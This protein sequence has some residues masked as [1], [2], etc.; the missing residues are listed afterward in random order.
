MRPTADLLALIPE[1]FHTDKLRCTWHNKQDAWYVYRQDA[2]VYVPEKKRG[3]EKRTQL[4]RI[5]DGKW[6]YSPSWLK[7]KEI[8]TLKAELHEQKKDQITKRL[9]Q[10]A[11]VLAVRELKNRAAMV[12]DPRQQLKTA[13]RL[14]HVMAVLCLAMVSGRTGAMAV[15][16][17]WSQH[18]YELS[19]IL[20][21]FPDYDISHDT[22]NR[23]L[24]L[25][26]PADF[27][28]LM[29]AFT[30][31]IFR[32]S[33]NR[34]IH[35]D[36]KAVRASKTDDA[37][38]GRYLLNVYDSGSRMFV[39]HELVG[40]KT[41]EITVI[42]DLI[43][44][45]DLKPGDIMTADAMHTQRATV[46]YLQ[47]IGCGYCLAVKDNQ[48]T[49]ASEV[50]RQF[51]A[52]VRRSKCHKPEP[53]SDHGRIEIRETEIMPGSIMSRKLKDLWP[54]LAEGSIVKAV[55][56]R[57]D[58]KS[59]DE[60]LDTR[61]FICT[62]PFKTEGSE[63]QI[64]DTVRA[65]WHVENKLHWVLDVIFGEDRIHATDPNY[66]TNLSL[67]L[68]AATNILRV[69]QQRLAEQGSHYTLSR[70]KDLCCTPMMAVE[71][72]GQYFNNF[73]LPLAGGDVKH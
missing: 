1:E 20:D 61:Y 49:L 63:R 23:L 5:K 28:P 37:K 12:S 36:G 8:E 44:K 55:T 29:S 62:I 2:V 65:H 19:R 18:R 25:I 13:Y 52:E 71:L 11:A 16:D 69:I 4:G 9:E 51:A 64:A 10:P 33:S 40:A 46:E 3:V 54:G 72:F 48:E 26:K 73:E 35:V 6:A 32:Q 7:A 38:S 43:K 68:K 58:K 39:A 70:L 47:S 67:C 24:R 27:L 42:V 59:N 57:I 53:E 15:A 14:D 50:M 21:G 22:V 34:L 17:Y 45:L 31:D 56:K 66:I 30:T 60:S 41:N